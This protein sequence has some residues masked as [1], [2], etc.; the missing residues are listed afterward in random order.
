MS[1]EAASTRRV[2]EKAIPGGKLAMTDPLFPGEK[3]LFQ[4][5]NSFG[6]IVAEEK[7]LRDLKRSVRL[8]KEKGKHSLGR[9]PL[10]S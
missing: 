3:I 5:V 4:A 7:T 6:R 10:F 8:L 9:S 2:I 1:K